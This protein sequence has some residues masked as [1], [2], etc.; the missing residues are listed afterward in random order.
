MGHGPMLVAVAPNGARKTKLDHA[1][2]PLTV[3]E[4]VKTAVGRKIYQER[5]N[6]TDL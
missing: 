3:V 2:L 5:A 6:R 1:K 4:L